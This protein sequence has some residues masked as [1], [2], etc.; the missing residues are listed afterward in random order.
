MSNIPYRIAILVIALSLS[1]PVAAQQRIRSGTL[2]LAG[3]SA[4]CGPI[5]TDVMHFS[6]IAASSGNRIIINPRLFTM[7]RAQQMFWYT[8]ECGHQIFGPSEPDADCWAIQQGR[9][10][11]WLN[12][13]EMRQLETLID[14]L[15]GDATHVSGP[16]RAAHM[17]QCYGG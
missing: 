9:Q 5:E 2:R 6:D 12:V 13:S 15:P 3:F 17:R 14:R 11:G 16:V 4:S 1:L 10:Q 8:H 7:P